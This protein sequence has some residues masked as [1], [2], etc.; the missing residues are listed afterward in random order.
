MH[1]RACLCMSISACVLVSE[2][3]GVKF[4]QLRPLGTIN[5][6]VLRYCIIYGGTFKGG[7]CAEASIN[8]AKFEKLNAWFKNT[9]V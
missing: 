2:G 3:L 6:N 1:L 9:V 8:Q 7:V 4:H 5:N